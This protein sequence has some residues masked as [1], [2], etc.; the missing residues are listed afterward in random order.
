MTGVKPARGTRGDEGFT[1]VELLITI[2]I[3]PLI[4][5]G[6]VVML[7][8]VFQTQSDVSNNLSGAGDST[9]TASAITQDV[10][11]ATAVTSEASPLACGTTGA[12]ILA[13]KDSE[14]SDISS[15]VVVVK[16]GKNELLREECTNSNTT[17]PF[18]KTVLSPN[19]PTG[20]SATVKCAVSTGC[21]PTTSFVYAAGIS[22]VTVNV[23]EASNGVQYAAYDVSAVPRLWN[24]ASVGLVSQEDPFSIPP[25]DILGT[26]SCGTPSMTLSGNATLLIAQGAG[27]SQDNS[28]CADSIAL[29]GNANISATELGTGD[30]TP[31]TASTT[32]G[33][34]VAP[35]VVYVAP[36]GDP[37]AGLTAPTNP[38]ATGAGTCSSSGSSGSC[39]PGTYPSGVNLSGDTWTID[40]GSYVF[41]QPVSISGNTTVIFGS[42]TYLF[43]GGLSISGNANVTF[44]S[45]T[46][47]CGSTS[48][49]ADAISVSGNADITSGPG[50]TLF[51]VESGLIAFS[52]NGAISLSGVAAYDGVAIWQAAS[53]TNVAMLSGNSAVNA[54]YGGVYVPSGEVEPSGN[55]NVSASFVVANEVSFGGNSSLSVG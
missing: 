2:V 16:N 21:S 37:L 18:S 53:D 31:S 33:N 9:V 11:S 34:V 28:T 35:P 30:S 40:T 45:G 44:D 51:Y 24:A 7:L 39:T 14:T 48:S 55:S 41:T 17:T 4:I 36:T 46:Y 49:S 42:G 22:D 25:L 26:S 8:L 29:S 43:E 23:T 1:L 12:Q 5:G 27:D 32:S 19:V 10:E 20:L 13:T 47:I 3:L 38:T 50:G 6:L 52:G 15:Y 54:A